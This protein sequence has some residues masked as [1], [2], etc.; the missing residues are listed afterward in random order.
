MNKQKI[1]V[2]MGGLSAER[3][4][5]LNSG[6]AVCNA[7]GELGLSYAGIDA[8][9]N[10]C[11]RLR[12]EGITLAFIALHGGWGE[13]G[14]IQGM[15]EIMGIPYTGSGVLASALAMNKEVSKKV[16]MN[17]GIRVAPFFVLDGKNADVAE[18]AYLQEG[19]DIPL[20]VK[21]VSEG[22]SVG[23]S[24]VKDGSLFKKSVSDALICGK[25]VI[26]EKYIK[27][28]EVHIGILGNRALGGV[29]VRPSSEFY[30]Y[31]A[32]YEGGTQ[33]ILPPELDVETYER[34][35]DAALEAHMALGCSGATRVDLIVD[36]N[37]DIYVLE[38]NTIPGMTRTSLLPKIAALAGYDF[39][40]LVREI[41]DDALRSGEGV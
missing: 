3:E 9:R 31:K 2:I 27:G 34:A 18:D 8:D 26:V 11:E 30:D 38:V 20:F 28:K 10:V 7:V 25:R 16:F 37:R 23:V 39:K 40:A 19:L 21:P 15:L 24:F 1:G 12:A 35:R 13:D 4:V 6:M 17:N 29:E 36:D 32:K 14:S 22:S 41:I 33:Y 5:S